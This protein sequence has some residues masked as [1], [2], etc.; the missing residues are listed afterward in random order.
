[1][2]AAMPSVVRKY[3]WAIA[4]GVVLA[5][6]FPT[7]RWWPIAWIALVPLFYRTVSAPPLE[8]AAQF[9]LTGWIFDSLLL[10]WLIT[11][12]FWGGGWAVIGY[13]LLCM[14]LG[15]FWAAAGLAWAW[16]RNHG[17]RWGRAAYL[18]ALWT[19]MEWGQANLF[20]GFGW[21]ALGYSQ[22]TD[23]A[24][25]Q[26]A[27]V[28][29]VSLISFF[30]V[31]GNALIAFAIADRRGRWPRLAAA[32]ALIAITH[33]VG[34]QLLQNPDYATRP[35]TVGIIQSDFPQELKWDAD[36]TEE[37]V[38]K[39]SE[40]SKQLAQY[41]NLDCFVWPE[42]VVMR[43]Y[44]RPELMRWLADASRSTGAYLFT[45]AQRDDYATGKSYN[46]SVLIDPDGNVVDYYDKVHLAPF[47][48]YMPFD[49][50]LPFLRQIVPQDVDAGS[51][52]KVLSLRDRRFGPMICFE[53]LFATIAENL[54]RQ[55]ADFLV[56][57]TNL[58]WFGMSNAIPQELEIARLRAIE[59]RL[60]LVHSANTGF[61]GVFDPWGRFQVINGIIVSN[62]E[63]RLL[64][65][66]EILAT[67]MHR[68]L[69]AL[70]VSAPA[71]RPLP[72]NPATFFLLAAIWITFFLGMALAGRIRRAYASDLTPDDAQKR[73][74]QAHG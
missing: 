27:A 68:L 7:F 73:K 19:V 24:L 53:V 34:A 74:R 48:E 70:P 28:G 15:V 30:L 4:S 25:A 42:A 37:M 67:R 49:K 39:S 65:D 60:P 52:H 32:V 43:D 63:F 33:V 71:R 38:R 31:L 8:T 6:C 3:G 22:G 45:G 58:S 17:P 46:S 16:G 66:P 41:T 23:L 44:S 50:F 21:S 72:V 36:Y 64:K 35:L 56:V 51:D 14:I 62:G 11:N 9:F 69:A 47:G 18:A 57:V 12:I 59:T 61:S 2:I 40:M 55:G 1:M 29:G 26:W 10:Q 54:R 20:T 5:F 13:Q